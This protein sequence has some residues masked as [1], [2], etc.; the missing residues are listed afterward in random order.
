MYIYHLCW[1]VGVACFA[2]CSWAAGDVSGN[3]L[4]FCVDICGVLSLVVLDLDLESESESGGL[5]LYL[6]E[7]E[8]LNWPWDFHSGW[9]SAE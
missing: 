2:F 8:R 1:L 7:Y 3:V 4:G 5:G 9:V 6:Q